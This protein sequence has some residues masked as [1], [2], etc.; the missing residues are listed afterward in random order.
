[1]KLTQEDKINGTQ[2]EREFASATFDMGI[3]AAVFGVA[4]PIGLIGP[5]ARV[6]MI[7]SFFSTL[8]QTGSVLAVIVCIFSVILRSLAD[9]SYQATVLLGLAASSASL[10]FLYYILYLS[11]LSYGGGGVRYH[12]G[13]TG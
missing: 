8:T 3:A 10:Q 5:F 6:H 13:S 2:V 9:F 1:M 12:T 7:S 4:A 11:G